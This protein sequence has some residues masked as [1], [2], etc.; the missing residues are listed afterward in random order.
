MRSIF[1]RCSQQTKHANSRNHKKI[2]AGSPLA[3]R[4]WASGCLIPERTCCNQYVTPNSSVIPFA[5]RLCSGAVRVHSFPATCCSACDF[6]WS[7]C[8]ITWLDL[9]GKCKRVKKTMQITIFS[10]DIKC[11]SHRF[12]TRWKTLPWQ[13]CQ[14]HTC[15]TR[16]DNRSIPQ[17]CLGLASLF[18]VQSL[19]SSDVID[20]QCKCTQLLWSC[21]VDACTVYTFHK[22]AL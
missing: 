12:R 6:T 1:I 8:S 7:M 4:K 19:C 5:L 16:N 10:L 11:N 15:S 17:A 13:Q 22:P 21:K 14:M 18:W 9:S 3:S 2:C 20:S